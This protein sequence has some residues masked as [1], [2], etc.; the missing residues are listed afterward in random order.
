V[1][2]LLGCALAVLALCAGGCSGGDGDGDAE[3]NLVVSL[4]DAPA[5]GVREVN[6]TITAVRIHQSAD[7]GTG[8]VGW[9]ELPVRSPMPVDLLRLR[10][11]VLYELCRARLGAGH[12][13]QVRLVVAENAGAGPPYRN[14]V[15]AAD[16]RLHPLEVPS[17]IKIVHSFRVADGTRTDLRLD[18]RAGDSLR[19]RGN[20]DY[21]LQPV[22]HAS[23]TAR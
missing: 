4:T 12:Y 7:A 10:G 6:V 3:A 1:K 5:D 21:Y 14:S 20:G 11:G 18:F 8:A 19:Q 17:D 9:R 2:R 22:I 23:S 13:Q 15:R 16:G